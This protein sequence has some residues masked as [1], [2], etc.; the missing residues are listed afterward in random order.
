MNPPAPPRPLRER[1]LPIPRDSGLRMPGYFVWCGSMIRADGRFH[2]FASRWPERA[3]FPDGYR[4]HSEI[5]R[6][7]APTPLGP[8]TFREVVLAGRGGGLWDGKMCHNPKIAEVGGR[9]VLYYIGSAVGSGLRKVGYAV[10]DSVYGPW[11]RVAEPLPLGEDANNP[12]PYFHPDGSVLLA[13]RDRSLHMHIARAPAYDGPYSVVAQDIFPAGMLEDPDLHVRDGRYHLIVEDNAGLL[14]GHVRHGG[15]LTS[16][17][18]LRW[19]PESPAEAYTHTLPWADGATETADRRERP[20]LFNAHAPVKGSGEP[21]HLIT[22]VLL[23]GKSWCVV[24]PIA[25]R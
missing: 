22:G 9:C 24:Q 14:T 20:E 6:A 18:V 19:V 11:E 8:F 12:A 13:Y 2:L 16:D 4:D 23:N 10:A 5:V 7:D 21:T 17:D 1:L 15:H 25:P 3:A